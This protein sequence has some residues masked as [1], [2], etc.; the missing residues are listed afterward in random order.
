M[1]K[2]DRI[3]DLNELNDYYQLMCLNALMFNDDKHA[4][5]ADALELRAVC[6]QAIKVSRV[7]ARRR[8]L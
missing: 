7:F 8:C 5:H 2:D 1:I 3:C 6:N 4:I